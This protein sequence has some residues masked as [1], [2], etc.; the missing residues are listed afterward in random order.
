MQ[1]LRAP[2]VVTLTA[3]HAANRGALGDA[4]D[5]LCTKLEWLRARVAEDDKDLEADGEH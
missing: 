1:H 2:L 5:A 3:G 4:L